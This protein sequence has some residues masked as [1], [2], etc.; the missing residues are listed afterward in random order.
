[1]WKMINPAPKSILDVGCGKGS[2]IVRKMRAKI[3]GQYIVGCDIFQPYIRESK[4]SGLY[5]DCVLA[6]AR[7]LPFISK[8]FEFVFCL[9][10]IEHLEKIEGEKL[11]SN[12]E[13]LASK[14]V[15][16]STPVGFMPQNSIDNNPYH[17][18]K[19]AWFPNEFKRRGYKVIGVAGPFFI[20]EKHKYSMID[21][22]IISLAQIISVLLQPLFYFIP[23]IAFQ[24]ICIKEIQN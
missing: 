2:S 11:L 21:K 17:T 15:V 3:R 14:E 19:S 4:Q 16:I 6:D 5:D 20:R 13:N 12:L 9:E 7:Y 23:D 24:M 18:H 1:M 10:V 22:I 8:S